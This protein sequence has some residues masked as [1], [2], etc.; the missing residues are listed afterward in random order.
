MHDFIFSVV[1][2]IVT[3]ERKIYEGLS[4]VLLYQHNVK[5]SDT[6][7]WWGNLREGTT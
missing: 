3:D 7:L 5:S 1:L 2:E 6:G 4:Y